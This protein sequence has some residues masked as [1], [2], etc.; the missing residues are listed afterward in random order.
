MTDVRDRSEGVR[1]LRRGRAEGTVTL[2]EAWRPR[3]EAG[4]EN[5]RALE[6]ARTEGRLAARRVPEL[7]ADAASAEV[8]GVDIDWKWRDDGLEL[9]AEVEGF[10]RSRLDGRALAALQIFGLSLAEASDRESDQIEV[11]VTAG[12]SHA[13]GRKRPV[14]PPVRAAVVVVSSAVVSGDKEDRAG[15]TVREKI[16]A[17]ADRGV[18]RVAGEVLPDEPDRLRET[19]EGMLDEGVELIVTVGGTGVTHDDHTVETLEPMLDSEVPG[20]MEAARRYGLDRTPYAAVSRG[21]ILVLRRPR[22]SYRCD[23]VSASLFSNI[24]STNNPMISIPEALQHIDDTVDPLPAGPTP[25]GESH[26]RGLAD[27]LSAASAVPGFAQSAMDGYGLRAADVVDAAPESPV[28]L[29]V[30]GEVAAGPSDERPQVGR[31]EA[32]RIFT[33]APVPEGVDAVIRQEKVRREDDSVLVDQ[34]VRE[35]RDLRPVGEELEAGEA[36]GWIG[37]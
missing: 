7:V 15:E 27:E 6:S 2:P 25:V 22:R 9:V 33:G 24:S 35:G 29:T 18:E 5:I 14:E 23:A 1:R 34:P 16:D 8:T 12:P 32:V 28:R 11:D 31:G 20:L 30:V 37:V 4:D 13:D 17:L 10:A 19:V 26:G 3:L 36:V 21:V